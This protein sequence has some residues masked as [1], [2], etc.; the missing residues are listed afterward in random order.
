MSRQLVLRRPKDKLTQYRPRLIV[1]SWILVFATVAL[2]GC[3]PGSSTDDI[4][5]VYTS[6]DQPFAEPILDDFE[7][8]TG[9]QV[10]AV[11]DVEAAK[12]TGLVNR[13]IAEKDLPQADVFWNGEILQTIVLKENGVLEAYHS[14]N[15]SQIPSTY[16]DPDGFWT[17]V[18]A[19]ARVLIVNTDR[20]A[21]PGSIDSIDDLLNPTWPGEDVGIAYPLFG[22]TATHAAALYETLGPEQ[23]RSYFE[24]LADRGV[25][26]VDGNSVVRDLVASGRLAFGL[27]DTDDACVSLA[28]GDPIAINL[29]DQDHLGTLLIPSTVALI[30]SAPHPGQGRALVDYLLARETEQT[31][32]DADFSHIPL[33]EGIGSPGSCL[34]TAGIRAM[35]V[36]YT[37]VYHY[38]EAVQADMREVFLR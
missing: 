37:R 20:V 31:L 4:V 16:R 28:R 17:G 29:P 10:R 22:T 3:Q 9:I 30:A 6:V 38:F 15:A 33:H 7:E 11:Y 34:S 27:T 25:Q 12:T 36:D 26:V 8:A 2:C 5:V 1:W 21:R 13:L 24:T 14:P 35:D 23:A 18:A 32:I 19:R